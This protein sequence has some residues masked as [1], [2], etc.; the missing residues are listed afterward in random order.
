MLLSEGLTFTQFAGLIP[1]GRAPAHHHTYDEVVHVV[2]GQGVVHLSGARPTSG[3]ARRST[4]RRISHTVWRIRA[5]VRWRCSG[6]S[7]RLA[8][9]PPSRPLEAPG[10]SFWRGPTGVLAI[11]LALASAIGYGASDFAAGLA[12]RRAGIIQVTLLASAVSA[13]W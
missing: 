5:R 2:A 1:P 4:C 9:R 13:S 12:S 10:L 7:I 6:S 3:R 11:V 8:A